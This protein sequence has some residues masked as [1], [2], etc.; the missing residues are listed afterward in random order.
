MNSSQPPLGEAE[1]RRFLDEQEAKYARVRTDTFAQLIDELA[2]SNMDKVSLP[3]NETEWCGTDAALVIRLEDA[4][5][6]AP[7]EDEQAI[8]QAILDELARV[9]RDY[10]RKG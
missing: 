1:S 5:V 9:L 10:G 2:T 3:A 8:R 7:K 6:R 4:A